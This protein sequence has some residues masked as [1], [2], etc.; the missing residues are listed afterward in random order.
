MRSPM[1]D[2]PRAPK[3]RPVPSRGSGPAVRVLAAGLALA[4]LRILAAG[5]VLAAVAVAAT[6][7][8][9][10]GQGIPA[11]KGLP[12]E[13]RQ[14]S[15]FFSTGRTLFEEKRV[16]DARNVYLRTVQELV[17]A[18]PQTNA[19]VAIVQPVAPVR[20]VEVT[21]GVATLDWGREVLDFRASGPEKVLA[22]AAFLRT[23]GQFP[24]V[25]KVRFTVEGRVDGRIGGKDVA[26]FWG[27]IGLRG[28]PWAVLRPKAP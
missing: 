8:R 24:E 5:L 28:Q 9:E 10:A 7:C 27:S 22:L 11:P 14:V 20:S 23:F 3:G 17:L 4:A 13:T 16:V 15:V 1:P 12:A 2:P 21:G 26:R 19:D 6:G 18:S 25:T